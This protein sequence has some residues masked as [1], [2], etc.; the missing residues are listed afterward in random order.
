MGTNWLKWIVYPIY[1]IFLLYL[2][3]FMFIRYTKSTIQMY[4]N[5][6][7]KYPKP[8]AYVAFNVTCL[9]LYHVLAV[10]VNFFAFYFT[11]KLIF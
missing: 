1:G 3:E 9:F 5:N 2:G 6:S 10:S 7:V 4:L 8:D 11:F